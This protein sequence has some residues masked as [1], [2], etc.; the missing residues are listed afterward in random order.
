[1]EVTFEPASRNGFATLA[2]AT[3]LTVVCCRRMGSFRQPSGCAVAMA[4]R[5]STLHAPLQPAAAVN[6]LLVVDELL[7]PIAVIKAAAKL[8]VTGFESI[9]DAVTG[10]SDKIPFKL[11]NA[12]LGFL[13]AQAE[14]LQNEDL[15]KKLKEL[16]ELKEKAEQCT[17]AAEK[18]QE[19]VNKLREG[20]KKLVEVLKKKK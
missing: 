2:S 8:F 18:C 16:K 17:E 15:V 4:G 12:L 7:R 20:I 14:A 1:M 10:K 6:K 11:I 3:Q 5:E 9:L 19:L 13:I